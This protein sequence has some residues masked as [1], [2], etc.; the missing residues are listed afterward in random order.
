MNYNVNETRNT[1]IKSLM[2]NPALHKS[3]KKKRYLK[4]IYKAIDNCGFPESARVMLEMSFVETLLELCS[5]HK[6]P[7]SMFQLER[8]MKEG[9]IDDI[10]DSHMDNLTQQ[11]K[12]DP[13]A[14]DFVE[15]TKNDSVLMLIQRGKIAQQFEDILKPTVETYSDKFWAQ[16]KHICSICQ[17]EVK[18]QESH[19]P[20]P[21]NQ[22]RC[23]ENCNE[24]VVQY[25]VSQFMSG[26]AKHQQQEGATIH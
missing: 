24:A 2:K 9:M 4:S 21:L 26:M 17:T 19:N 8:F 3:E 7:I 14:A 22:G 15:R 23:C 1:L 11:G 20:E 12:T 18:M 10:V 25:R 5:L 6:K 13:G 16:D